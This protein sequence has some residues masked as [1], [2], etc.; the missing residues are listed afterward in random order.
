MLGFLVPGKSDGNIFI[1]Q[2]SNGKSSAVQL[3]NV[4]SGFFYH[5]VQWR[6]MNN[7]GRLDIITARANKGLFS[8]TAELLWLEQP[9]SN[10]L[11]G[12][13]W[14]EHTLVSGP[15]APDVKFLLLNDTG[16]SFYLVSANFF[17]S[18]L[19]LYEIDGLN[20]N[21]IANR[22]L[23]QSHP[24]YDIHLTD[25]SAAGAGSALV[26]TTHEAGQGGFVYAYELPASGDLLQGN[27]TKHTLASGFPVTEGGFNQAAPGFLT[28][29]TQ[30][31]SKAPWFFLAGD[32]SQSAYILSPSS[33]SSAFDYQVTLVANVKGVVGIVAASALNNTDGKST[34]AVPNYDAGQ[35]SFYKML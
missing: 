28:P 19:V 35:V 2:C 25:F 27:W 3:T 22:T 29:F 5:Y 1:A 7:D 6:D 9:A 15:S 4:K 16:S 17:S 26:V 24:F 18:L 31:G 23:D 21:V 11:G 32:G 13:K 33:S 8:S 10:P 20:G 34:F 30:P 12:A 14:K